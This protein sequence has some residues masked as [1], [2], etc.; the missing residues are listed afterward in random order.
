MKHARA[1]DIKPTKET[2]K[3]PT[4]SPY[5]ITVLSSYKREKGLLSII[6]PDI[7]AYEDKKC[8]WG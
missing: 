3:T 5:H 2:P 7:S 8:S 4:S 6:E 1:M